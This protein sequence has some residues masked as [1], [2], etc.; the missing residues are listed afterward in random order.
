MHMGCCTVLNSKHV[1]LVS[2]SVQLIR[3]K[4]QIF[5]YDLVWYV[6]LTVFSCPPP[7][8]TFDFF[9]FTLKLFKSVT[10]QISDW[11]AYYYTKYKF[12][13]SESDRVTHISA[14]C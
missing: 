11:Q 7:D 13:L 10:V 3:S 4:Y 1:F 12:T 14:E 5:L 9:S 8:L 2:C 6:G